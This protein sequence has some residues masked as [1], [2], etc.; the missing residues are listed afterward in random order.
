MTIDLIVR[1]TLERKLADLQLSPA[2]LSDVRRRSRVLRRRRLVTAVVGVVVTAGTTA[3]LVTGVGRTSEPPASTVEVPV[4]DFASGLRGAYDRG[5]GETQLGGQTFRLGDVQDLGTSAESTPYGLVFFAADQSVRL[6]PAD[7]R[8]RTIAGPPARRDLEFVPTVRYD[9]S[10]GSLAWLTRG[11]GKVTLTVYS[12]VGGLRQLGSVDVP[13]SGSQCSS[14]EMVSHD[15]G[16][17]FVGDRRGTRVIDPAGGAEATWAEIPSGHVVDVHNRVILMTGAVGAD[18]LPPQLADGTWRTVEAVSDE[19][20][21]TFD[22]AWQMED[23]ATLLST[24]VPDGTL[25]FRVPPGEGEIALGLDSDGT[26][27]V[28]RTDEEATTFWDCDG[29]GICAEYARLADT[30]GSSAFIGN[31]T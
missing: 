14:L 12:L 4:M 16:L 9:P 19:S 24:A 6:L 5:T 2:D 1:E 26:I 25:E 8:V 7:G 22:G 30:D 17:V 28:A 20:I 13:C 23:S 3:A 27:I 21:L 10:R 18:R 31:H 11:N 29:A 15:Q